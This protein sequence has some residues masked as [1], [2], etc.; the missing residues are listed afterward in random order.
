MNKVWKAISALSVLTIIMSCGPTSFEKKGDVAYRLAQKAQGDQKRI[1]FKTA[2]MMYDKAVKNNPN[3]ISTKLRNRY[4]EMT[5]I[6]ANMVLNEG[7]VYMD[8]IPLFLEDVKKVLTPE[9]SPDLKQQLALFLTQMADS[10]IAKNKFD[11]AI[12]TIDQ[13]IGYASDPTPIKAKK[14]EFVKRIAQDNYDMADMDYNNGKQNKDAEDYIRAE[15][16]ALTAL[17]FDS[18]HEDAKKLLKTL[19]KE[20]RSTYSAYLR[21]IDPIPDSAVFKKINKYDIL[22]AIPTL[23]KKGK[24]VST[25]IDLYNYS[26]NPLRLKSEHFHLVDVNGKRYTAKQT[27]LEPEILDQEHEAKCKLTFPAP[28]AEIE[29]L[30]YENGEHYSEKLFF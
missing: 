16:Y 23:S 12:E 13:A 26:Y 28:S 4:I 8:A 1:Q 15:F 25:I 30:I 20:N 3:S 17:Y 11:E 14:Q 27:R 9:V 2:Y 29:K 19:R 10:S 5:L 24:S 21:V 7:A 22:L 6:R 18:T